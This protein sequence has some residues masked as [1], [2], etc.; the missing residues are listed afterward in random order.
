[1]YLFQVSVKNI[2]QSEYF[3]KLFVDEQ[4]TCFYQITKQFI[5]SIYS[6]PPSNINTLLSLNYIEMNS[7]VWSFFVNDWTLLVIANWFQQNVNW[8][9]VH[10]KHQNWSPFYGVHVVQSWVIYEVYC[11]RGRV[12]C[13]IQLLR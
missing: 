11:R 8:W 13:V 3:S 4:A 12:F 5:N 2:N 9:Q 1:M 7:H 6:T 10:L